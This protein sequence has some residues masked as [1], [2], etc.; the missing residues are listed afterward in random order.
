V[1][2]EWIQRGEPRPAWWDD[3]KHGA[4]TYRDIP[5]FCMSVSI[6]GIGK[7]GFVLAPGRYVGAEEQE[8][9]SEPFTEKYQRLLAELETELAAGER[10][11][12][13]VR[14]QLGRVKHGG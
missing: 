9:D 4:W 13:V 1:P 7:H 3:Q 8:Q 6:A 12:A 14:E 2:S 10:L 5:G 11:T